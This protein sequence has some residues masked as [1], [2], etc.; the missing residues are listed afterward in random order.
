[1]EA[2]TK[3][4]MEKDRGDSDL[5]ECRAPVMLLDWVPQKHISVRHDCKDVAHTTN[6]SHGLHAVL[7]DLHSPFVEVLERLASAN[8]LCN[9]L[10][11]QL[12]QT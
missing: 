9:L 12:C 11:Q 2:Q 4:E 10:Q 6:A 5:Q 3:R 1:M 8:V 7:G